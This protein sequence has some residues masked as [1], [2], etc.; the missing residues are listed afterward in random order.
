MLC[1]V[2]LTVDAILALLELR[3]PLFRFG[4]LGV[5]SQISSDLW[6]YHGSG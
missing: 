2:L 4:D 3:S 5:R 1:F 6:R